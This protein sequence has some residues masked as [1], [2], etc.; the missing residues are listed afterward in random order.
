MYTHTY[1]RC[2]SRGQ[3]NTCTHMHMYIHTY[4]HTHTHTVDVLLEVSDGSD[5]W[6]RAC[7]WDKESATL[8]VVVPL[9]IRKLQ[10]AAGIVLFY[11][12]Y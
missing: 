7:I 6:A 3:T 11:F 10:P 9:V 5:E 8:H 12:Y 1:S 4:I 2:A